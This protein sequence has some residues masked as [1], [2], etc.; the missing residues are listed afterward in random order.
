[1][2]AILKGDPTTYEL[3]DFR[4]IMLRPGV[5]RK[6]R[7]LCYDRYLLLCYKNTLTHVG[8][9]VCPYFRNGSCPIDRATR[10]FDPASG[11]TT[12]WKDHIESHES[13]G[14]AGI[15]KKKRGR[16]AVEGTIVP[17]KL[18][19]MAKKALAM[20]AARALFL[21]LRQISFAEPAR[22]I[23][24]FAAC[25]FEEGQRMPAAGVPDMTDYLPSA[26]AVRSSLMEMAA[27]E[28]KYDREISI[29][30]AMAVGGGMSSDGLKKKRTGIKYYD[31]TLQYLHIG[32]TTYFGKDREVSMRT[33]MLFLA[34]HNRSRGESATAIRRTLDDAL[35]MRFSIDLTELQKS[36]CFVTDWATTMPNIVG[37]STSRTRGPLTLSWSGCSAHQL[38]TVLSAAFD[39]TKLVEAEV[40]ELKEDLCAM[41]TVIRIFK[42]SDLN[43]LLPDGEALFPEVETRFH[44]L[45]DV[46]ERFIKSAESVS[47]IVLH[48]GAENLRDAFEC[49]AVESIDGRTSYPNLA[50]LRSVMAP[51]ADG[52]KKLQASSVP[53]IHLVLPFYRHLHTLL[54]SRVHRIAVMTSISR[55]DRMTGVLAARALRVMNSKLIVHPLHIAA[56]LLHPLFRTLSSLYQDDQERERAKRS[57]KG[58]RS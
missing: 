8:W 43:S 50:A 47:H 3:R 44:H 42:Q 41:R 12:S 37:A 36:L 38:S 13:G 48:K 32:G 45:H 22:G 4:T 31:L 26:A 11:G 20:A 46:A 55:T 23:S 57:R 54:T 51:F 27:A 56:L 39:E 6:T 19:A 49:L 53:T 24:E 52:I 1:V 9:A 18:G 35:L 58:S 2:S 7:T 16:E 30:A 15:L 25:L 5:S 33:R 40:Q 17:R 34:E 29:P 14:T 21:D 28:Q 10:K